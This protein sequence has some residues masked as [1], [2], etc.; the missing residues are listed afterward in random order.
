MDIFGTADDIYFCSS[1]FRH[2]ACLEMLFKHNSEYEATK[3]TTHN[4]LST[5]PFK[6]KS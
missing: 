5:L 4:T 1:L 6:K 3:P 2:D